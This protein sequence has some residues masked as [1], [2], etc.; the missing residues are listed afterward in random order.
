MRWF[1]ELRID[2]IR[3]FCRASKSYQKIDHRQTRAPA[4]WS[5]GHV[6]FL[7]CLLGNFACSM[8]CL[9]E[10]SHRRRWSHCRQEA[11][12]RALARVKISS[13]RA[14]ENKYAASANVASLAPASALGRSHGRRWRSL[15]RRRAAWWP[16]GAA[17]KRP[18]HKEK[19]AM[20]RSSF[21]RNSLSYF[22][23]LRFCFRLGSRSV[24]HLSLASKCLWMKGMPLHQR[25]LFILF[26][27]Y[28]RSAKF[29]VG[30]S[31][32]TSRA[33]LFWRPKKACVRLF[34]RSFVCLVCPNTKSF[35]K[36][37]NRTEN[38]KNGVSRVGTYLYLSEHCL[39]GFCLFLRAPATSV[40]SV[41]PRQ[42][43]I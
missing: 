29:E 23:V 17:I 19:M 39:T 37:K 42:N 34:V 26:I 20:P 32:L 1:S 30:F 27:S 25:H 16:V 31:C 9:V 43:Y 3:I 14:T 7:P 18:V 24:R 41:R 28:P 5:L 22:N 12:S 36:I 10:R 21:C 40:A 33:S 11:E 35:D 6:F 38:T 15:G 8:V 4:S 2:R 13:E